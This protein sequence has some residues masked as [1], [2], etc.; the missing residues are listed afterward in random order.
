VIA[1]LFTLPPAGLPQLQ[2]EAAAGSLNAGALP[3]S[4]V[5]V[6]T[7]ALDAGGAA[8]SSLLLVSGG[9][10]D[11]SLVRRQP[12]GQQQQQHQQNP[13]A[14]AAAALAPPAFPLR[15]PPPLQ[16]VRPVHLVAAFQLPPPPSSPSSSPGASSASAATE[17]AAAAA[18]AAA[19]GICCIMWAGRPRSERQASRCEVYAVRLVAAGAE[20]GAA[21]QVQGVQLLKVRPML[22]CSVALGLSAE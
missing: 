9:H 19:A 22:T 2:P 11:V 1:C 4:V 8:T 14:A 17:A 13:S 7:A 6:Q 12:A 10:G 20:A 3:P 18:A 5:E 21:L 16:G 15:P